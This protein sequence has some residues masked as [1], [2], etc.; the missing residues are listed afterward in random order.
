M[1]EKNFKKQKVDKIF[2]YFLGEKIKQICWSF[3]KI[4]IKKSTK[5]KG[6]TSKFEKRKEE[7]MLQRTPADP[8][9]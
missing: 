4:K 1:I 8:H 2:Y 3:K 6:A 5:I 9:Y 7:I